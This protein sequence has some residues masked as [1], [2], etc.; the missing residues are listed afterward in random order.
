M[1]LG[2]GTKRGY[3]KQS[4]YTGEYRLTPGDLRL[5]FICFLFFVKA[6]C[7]SIMRAI[8]KAVQTQMA[9]CPAMRFILMRIVTPLASKEAFVTAVAVIRFLF[10]PE[11]RECSEESQ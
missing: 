1:T 3:G 9:F 2:S 10:Q 8:D 4:G 7:N 6:K 5:W 11:Y